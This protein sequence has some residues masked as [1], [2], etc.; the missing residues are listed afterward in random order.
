MY[1]T[2]RST[3]RT[4]RPTA[5][6][7]PRSPTRDV[8]L[9]TA[10]TAEF[11]TAANIRI[12]RFVRVARW[13]SPTLEGAEKKPHSHTNQPQQLAVRESGAGPASRWRLL[14]HG[15]VPVPDGARPLYARASVTCSTI[16][17]LDR[18]LPHV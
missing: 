13:L 16:T 9:S 2:V 6:N 5:E 1:S 7:E 12:D 3:S 18:C 4:F 15:G 14:E 17:C 11:W 8:R 10:T